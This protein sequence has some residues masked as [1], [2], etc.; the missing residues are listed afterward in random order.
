MS[1]PSSL[2]IKIHPLCR[3]SK[4]KLRDEIVFVR[5]I[6][7]HIYTIRRYCVYILLILLLFPLFSLIHPPLAIPSPHRLVASPSRFYFIQS[8][9]SCVSFLFIGH[10]F[11]FQFVALALALSLSR[12]IKRWREERKKK[13]ENRAIEEAGERLL[14]NKWWNDW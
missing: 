9:A 12:K 3:K 8:G 13:F 2:P 1:S 4:W 14:S 7:C 11:V 10:G 6:I 5:F